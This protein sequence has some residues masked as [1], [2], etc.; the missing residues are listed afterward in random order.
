MVTN[1]GALADKLRFLK[2]H[3]MDPLRRYWHPEIGFNYRMTNLQAALGCAQIERFEQMVRQR[4]ALIDAYRDALS[5]LPVKVNPAMDWARPAPWLATVLLPP[6]S[7]AAGL[8]KELR[9]VGVDTRPFFAPIQTMPPYKEF[10]SLSGSSSP[11]CP[12][13]SELYRRGILLPTVPTIRVELLLSRVHKTM[14]NYL[15][16]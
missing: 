14:K 3:A 16:R 4:Q 10:R 11:G 6:N 1:D 12:V 9:N 5:D 2:D 8:A 7:N 13:A 15:N